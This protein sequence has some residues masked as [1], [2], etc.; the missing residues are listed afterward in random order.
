MDSSRDQLSNVVRAKS[1]F[2]IFR[3]WDPF[4]RRTRHVIQSYQIFYGIIRCL[5]RQLSGSHQTV[6]RQSSGRCH[7]SWRF[8]IYCAVFSVFYQNFTCFGMLSTA[9]NETLVDPH[10]NSFPHK[11]QS[12]PLPTIQQVHQWYRENQPLKHNLPI[13][14][15]PYQI[16]S[17]PG[18]I[19]QPEVPLNLH[20]DLN[21]FG[22]VD[23]M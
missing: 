3:E 14:K 23:C 7:N 4:C 21:S 2:F 19:L 18:Q 1:M 12:Y 15:I 17:P 11:P 5:A 22:F 6:V 13:H 9:N 10:P 16:S 8:V 20:I